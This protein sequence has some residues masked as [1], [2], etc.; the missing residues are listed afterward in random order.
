MDMDEENVTDR[1]VIKIS[2][3]APYKLYNAVSP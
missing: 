2:I 1:N 3:N